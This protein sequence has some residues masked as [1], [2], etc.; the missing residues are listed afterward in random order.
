MKHLETGDEE[1]KLDQNKAES[2][3]IGMT[4]LSAGLLDNLEDLYNFRQ[5]KFNEDVLKDK[6]KTWRQDPKFS[7]FFKLIVEKLLSVDP[8]ERFSPGEMRAYLSPYE[9]LIKS[10]QTYQPD[11]QLSEAYLQ[12]YRQS[13]MTKKPSGNINE[14]EPHKGIRQLGAK[15]SRK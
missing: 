3:S 6:I 13:K 15:F 11:Y 5:P 9:D 14:N 8:V 12:K 1:T 10:L 7:G 4:I 2:F